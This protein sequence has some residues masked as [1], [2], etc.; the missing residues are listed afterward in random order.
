MAEIPT[1]RCGCLN[2][3]ERR[4][5]FNDDDDDDDDDDES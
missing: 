5:R 2:P 4:R 3:F 1:W